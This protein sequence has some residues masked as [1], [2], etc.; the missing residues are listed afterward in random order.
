MIQDIFHEVSKIEL[1]ARSTKFL[2][3]DVWGNEC[4]KLVNNFFKKETKENMNKIQEKN[5]KLLTNSKKGQQFK[6][7]TS[8][9]LKKN[10]NKLIKPIYK[11][12]KKKLKKEKK[13]YKMKTIKLKKN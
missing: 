10:D 12:K 3:W 9:L 6:S 5:F 8:G 7:N 2:N 11:I 4:T 1:F 13:F